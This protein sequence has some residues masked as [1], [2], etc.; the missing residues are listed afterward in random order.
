MLLFL[1]KI[2]Y[3]VNVFFK[4]VVVYKIEDCGYC[5]DYEKLIKRNFFCFKKLIIEYS[6]NYKV[7]FEVI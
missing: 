2:Y 7:E 5:G 1:D 3:G 4:R 6:I